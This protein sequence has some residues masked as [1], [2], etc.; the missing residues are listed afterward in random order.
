VVLEK[1]IGRSAFFVIAAILEVEAEVKVE[2]V[3][4]VVSGLL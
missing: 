4:I 1:L 3:L 2:R